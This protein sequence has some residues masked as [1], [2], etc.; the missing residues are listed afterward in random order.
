MLHNMHRAVASKAGHLVCAL[1]SRRKRKLGDAWWRSDGRN[2]VNIF[3]GPRSIVQ[4]SRSKKTIPSSHLCTRVETIITRYNSNNQLTRQTEKLEH[5]LIAAKFQISS[6]LG[7]RDDWD[8][9]SFPVIRVIVTRTNTK[10]RSHSARNF[11][12]KIFPPIES[13]SF[14]SGR[15]RENR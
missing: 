13:R 15:Q 11:S 14:V 7:K 12:R 8:A 4:T 1:E 5:T 10:A 3:R 9:A 6:S 2:P